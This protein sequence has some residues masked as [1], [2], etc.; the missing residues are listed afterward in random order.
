[1]CKTLQQCDSCKI[2]CNINNFP[3]NFNYDGKVVSEMG[4]WS[5]CNAVTMSISTYCRNIMW[6]LCDSLGKNI[7]DQQYLSSITNIPYDWGLLASQLLMDSPHKGPVAWKAFPCHDIIMC[8][9]FLIPLSVLVISWI[10]P[11]ND[12]GHSYDQILGMNTHVH[13]IHKLALCEGA[14]LVKP[15][16]SGKHWLVTCGPFY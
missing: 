8:I 13:H 6:E 2:N 4:P 12:L 16:V 9:L 15:V 14:W 5:T 11:E 1:M 3:L 10:H 7:N